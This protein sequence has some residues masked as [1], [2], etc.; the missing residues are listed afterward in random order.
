MKWK[1]FRSD[2]KPNECMRVWY[3]F[4]HSEKCDKTRKKE[5]K[6][7]NRRRITTTTTTERNK[8]YMKYSIFIFISRIWSLTREPT[9]R[10]S[11]FFLSLLQGTTVSNQATH[12][13]EWSDNGG[14]WVRGEWEE[15]RG[16]VK[17]ANN[18]NK[19]STWKYR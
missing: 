1:T 11:S 2:I 13:H 8:K 18:N 3:M 12:T 6:I 5:K 15:W 10:I 17:V 16:C 4:S 7:R 14:M 9:N 19:W